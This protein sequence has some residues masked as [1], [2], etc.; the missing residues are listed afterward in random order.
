MAIGL[1]SQ[2]T[3]RLAA[4]ERWVRDHAAWEISNSTCQVILTQKPQT[5]TTATDT[6]IIFE[7]EVY[8]PDDLWDVGTPTVITTIVAGVYIITGHVLWSGMATDSYQRARITING[9][10]F[11]GAAA[12]AVTGKI[13]MNNPSLQYRLAVGDAVGMEVRQESGGDETITHAYLGITRIA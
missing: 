6:D 12:G 2:I 1:T 3:Q 11:G 10:A 5:I 7:S 13:G 8:D 4:V 9:T